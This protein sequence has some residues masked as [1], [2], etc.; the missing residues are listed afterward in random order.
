MG[1]DTKDAVFAAAL[2][3][4]ESIPVPVLPPLVLNE[5]S[6]G[7][8]EVMNAGTTAADTA[9]FIVRMVSG[10]VTTDA[11]LPSQLLGG[12]AMLSLP[13][14]VPDGAR[15]VL[16]GPDDRTSPGPAPV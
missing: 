13:L 7:Q 2:E 6:P 3:V 10:D 11:P 9:G 12:G 16:M 8:V 1:P 5:V 14:T 15:L 4:A